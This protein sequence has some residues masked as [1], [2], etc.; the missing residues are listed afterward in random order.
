[1]K[2]VAKDTT[3]IKASGGIKDTETALKYIDLGAQR[4]GTSSGIAIMKG[5]KSNSNY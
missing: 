1:M 5:E 4:L 2:S 3:K